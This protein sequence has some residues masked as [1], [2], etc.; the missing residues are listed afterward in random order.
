MAELKI[1]NK[2]Q[3]WGSLKK[4]WTAYRIAKGK[5]DLENQK[6]YAKQIVNLS[7]SLGLETPIFPELNH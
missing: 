4:C 5:K 3:R 6:E 2:D 7:F 1:P